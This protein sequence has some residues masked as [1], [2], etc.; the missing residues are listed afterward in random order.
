MALSK[1]SLE[2]RIESEFKKLGINTTGDHC[3]AYIISKAIARAVVDEI[4]SNA[5]VPV[6]KGDS[7]GNYKVT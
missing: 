6:T 4:Q 1:T 5:V 3:Y 2:G 7:A